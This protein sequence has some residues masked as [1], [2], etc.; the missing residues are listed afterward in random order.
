M[1]EIDI[2]A[3]ETAFRKNGGNRSRHLA[4]ALRRG[5]DHHAREPGR[6]RQG[7]EFAALLGDAAVLVDGAERQGPLMNLMSPWNNG[8]NAGIAAPTCFCVFCLA[9]GK[10]KGIDTDRARETRTV[11]SRVSPTSGS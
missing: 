6:Q 4:R 1:A 9:R 5:I 11:S 3:A 7:S 10:E 2:V 8:G